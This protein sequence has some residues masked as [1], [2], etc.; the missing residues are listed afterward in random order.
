M[1]KYFKITFL[2]LIV[3]NISNSQPVQITVN[4]NSGKKQFSP[5][6]FGKNNVLPSTFLN[7]GTNEE[8]KKSQEAGIRLV[9]QSGGNNST[10]YNIKI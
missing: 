7:N 8:I 4:A 1:I 6:I 2:L 9:R 3:F 5:Y 10:K